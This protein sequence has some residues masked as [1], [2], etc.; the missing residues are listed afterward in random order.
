MCI[1]LRKTQN[2][3]LPDAI[4]A[5]TSLSNGYTL[6]TNNEKDFSKIQNLR[7]VNLHKL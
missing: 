1:Y 3:K 6:I 5:A 2:I 4:I 7:S